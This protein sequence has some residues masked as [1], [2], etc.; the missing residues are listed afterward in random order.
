MK[1]E[2]LKQMTR[3]FVEKW[4]WRRNVSIINNVVCENTTE[5]HEQECLS[6]LN[7]LLKKYKDYIIEGFVMPTDTYPKEFACWVLQN[8]E[9]MPYSDENYIIGSGLDKMTLNEL[10]D[11]WIKNVK[12]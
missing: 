5:R 6:D 4:G 3:E 12:K 8:V 2:K 9:H 7:A 1:T 10:Y 11:Y